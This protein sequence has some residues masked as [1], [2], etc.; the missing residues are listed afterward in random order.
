MAFTLAFVDSIAT[1][2]TVRLDL[3]TTDGTG[4]TTLIAGTDFGMPP[5]R[6]ATA[7]T[8]LTDGDHISASAYGNRLLTLQLDLSHLT[9]DAAATKLQ[10][11]ARELDRPNNFLRYKADTTDE[12]TFLTFR[13]PIA[14]SIWDQVDKAFSVQILAQPFAIGAKASLSKVTVTNNPAAVSNGSY[15]DITGVKGDVETPAYVLVEDLTTTDLI[16]GTRRRGTPS[17]ISYFFQCESMTP[18]SDTTLPGNDAAMSGSGSNYARTTFGTPTMLNRLSV[19][20]FPAASGASLRGTYR[21]YV[22]A[23]GNNTSTFQIRADIEGV[24]GATF[25]TQTITHVPLSS[26][27]RTLLDLGQITLPLGADPTCEG[28]SG[29]EKSLIGTTLTLWAARTVGAGNLDWD[30]VAI[31]PDDPERGD[32]WM[33]AR[34]STSQDVIIDGPN[35]MVYPQTVGASTLPSGPVIARSGRLPMLSPNVAQR[36]IMLAPDRAG[37]DAIFGDRIAVT[38][39][40]TISYWPRYLLVRP[41]GG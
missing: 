16:I 11:L 18:A 20:N 39:D 23:R 13:S 29:V 3:N 24:D 2:P 14:R 33:T 26:T 6:R 40:V 37:V 7:G 32:D 5:L 41:S 4:F 38:A 31:V 27:N 30:Y 28:Y 8:L 12:V 9:P 35:D 34:L 1:S 36:W 10:L 15:L 19:S 25:S 22:M 21:M 17:G